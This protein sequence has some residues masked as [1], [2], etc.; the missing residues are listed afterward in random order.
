M[1]LAD[2]EF[3]DS[4]ELFRDCLEDLRFG[5]SYAIIIYQQPIDDK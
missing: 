2:Q 4:E 5:M 3:K 1:E